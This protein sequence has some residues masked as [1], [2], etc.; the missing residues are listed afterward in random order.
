MCRASLI[1]KLYL[2]I[3][4]LAINAGL[5]VVIVVVVVVIVAFVSFSG[6]PNQWSVWSDCN[7][8]CGGGMRY[9]T[10]NCD[11]NNCTTEKEECSSHDCQPEPELKGELVKL[12]YFY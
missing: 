4:L 8:D 9:R 6:V 2:F 5:F 3:L 10:M 11:S 1:Y 7:S 12:C